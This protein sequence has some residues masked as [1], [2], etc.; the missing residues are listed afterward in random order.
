MYIINDPNK[1]IELPIDL[2]NRL[3]EIIVEYHGY[4]LIRLFNYNNPVWYIRLKHKKHFLKIK[5]SNK[6]IELVI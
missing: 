3:C 4:F 2:H 1:V 5:C 6:L